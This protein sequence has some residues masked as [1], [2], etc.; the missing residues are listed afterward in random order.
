MIEKS[1]QVLPLVMVALLLFPCKKKVTELSLILPAAPQPAV[2]HLA[3]EPK[4]LA[5][6]VQVLA[7]VQPQALELQAVHHHELAER[8]Q[9]HEEYQ[10]N[11]IH[12]NKHIN[13]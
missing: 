10:S 8:L 1:S 5:H 12:S 7:A 3:V 2:Q 11:T 4:V 9:T 13:L 6:A